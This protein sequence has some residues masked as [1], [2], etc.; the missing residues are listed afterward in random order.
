MI[1]PKKQ[2]ILGA[3]LTWFAEVPQASPWDWREGSGAPRT[4]VQYWL[5]LEASAGIQLAMRALLV[6]YTAY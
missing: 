1:A 6:Q 5:H 4:K 2:T 3:V